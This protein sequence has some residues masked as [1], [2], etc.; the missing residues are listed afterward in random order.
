VGWSGFIWHTSFSDKVVG[1][2]TP[3]PFYEYRHNDDEGE[4]GFGRSREG[5]RGSGWTVFPHLEPSGLSHTNGSSIIISAYDDCD[6]DQQDK[7]SP[8]PFQ[9]TQFLPTFP[10]MDNSCSRFLTAK[11]RY[12]RENIVL[13]Y[14]NIAPT[15][16]AYHF[17]CVWRESKNRNHPSP[18]PVDEHFGVAACDIYQNT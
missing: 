9:E 15:V 6:N 10:Q 16:L 17:R 1:E 4:R 5:G 8:L 14:A 2:N 13:A 12:N 18:P 7:D 11:G 3:G